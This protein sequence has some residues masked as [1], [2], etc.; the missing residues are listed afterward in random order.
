M[1]RFAALFYLLSLL[2][3][4]ASSLDESV[5]ENKGPHYGSIKIRGA[6]NPVYLNDSYA[7]ID[8]TQAEGA[9]RHILMALT[10]PQSLRFLDKTY[11][12]QGGYD[13]YA[14]EEAI[15]DDKKSTFQ[16]RSMAHFRMTIM[17]MCG[18]GTYKRF[19]LN[20][21]TEKA[22]ESNRSLALPSLVSMVYKLTDTSYTFQNGPGA[23]K[24]A[25]TLFEKLEKMKKIPEIFHMTISYILAEMR[26]LG[27]GGGQ[28]YCKARSAFDVL[29]RNNNLPW[30]YRN[31]AWFRVAEMNYYG[32]GGP[33]NF[34]NAK[35]LY[36]T[37][38]DHKNLPGKE[39]IIVNY[40]L[41]ELK[42]VRIGAK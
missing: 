25:R 37:I 26:Y 35:Y 16:E 8:V 20:S 40:R 5:Y 27:Q 3:V 42:N 10:E 7:C 6:F 22:L 13:I 2:P 17:E 12:K 11:E 32:Q 33:Q 23:M 18:V 21:I 14:I 9:L 4:K 28:D 15:R 24:E 1:K 39:L 29:K 31:I 30:L 34:W 38:K 36:E 41:L 19:D